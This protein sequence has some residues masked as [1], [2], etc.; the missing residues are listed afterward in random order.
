MSCFVATYKEYGECGNSRGISGLVPLSDCNDSIDSHLASLHLSIEKITES[1]VILARVGIYDVAQRSTEMMVCAKHRHILGK[2]W[3][4]SVSCQYPSH[5]G[6]STAVRSRYS[7]NL[8]MSKSIQRV[9][10]VFV[11]FGSGEI[12][13]V[14]RSIYMIFMYGLI[15]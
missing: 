15:D 14:H 11:P 8:A 7:V 9:Y 2:F 6:G 13:R 5:M 10:G 1:Q 12:L 4:S 3:R